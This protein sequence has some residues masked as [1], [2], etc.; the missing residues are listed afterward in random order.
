MHWRGSFKGARAHRSPV[1]AGI[2]WKERSRIVTTEVPSGI[3]LQDVQP[4]LDG[5]SESQACRSFG[6]SSD[7]IVDAYLHP[8]SSIDNVSVLNNGRTIHVAPGNRERII[9]THRRDVL[10]ITKCGSL[11]PYLQS[12]FP[13]L[14]NKSGFSSTMLCV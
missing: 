13:T 3:V 12:H 9:N 1:C 4:S 14:V 10:D 6:G 2:A 11:F 7:I 8:L 5:I